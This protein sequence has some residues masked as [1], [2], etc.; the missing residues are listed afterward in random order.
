MQ[1][2]KVILNIKFSL[3][4]CLV[5]FLCSKCALDTIAFFFLILLRA[6]ESLSGSAELKL[7]CCGQRALSLN[8]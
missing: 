5:W 2:L 4:K 3:L 8:K 1:N 6:I 7:I